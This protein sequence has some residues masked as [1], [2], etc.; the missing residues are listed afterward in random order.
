MIN[1]VGS[2]QYVEEQRTT[3]LTTEQ[4]SKTCN[5]VIEAIKNELPKEAHSIE[6][7]DFILE[8][9]KELLHS[10]PLKLQ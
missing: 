1:V 6:V 9:S 3:T 7:L 2:I 10:M 5:S 4:I 8:K